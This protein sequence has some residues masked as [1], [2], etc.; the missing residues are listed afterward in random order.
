VCDQVAKRWLKVAEIA[1]RQHGVISTGQLRN[2]GLDKHAVLH[3]RRSGF[4]HAVH[5]GVYA[6][7][8]PGISIEGRWMAAVL[9]CG[10]SRGEAAA[11]TALGRWRAALSHRSAAALWGLLDSDSGGVDVTVQGDAG[12][13][14][15]RGIRVHRSVSLTAAD[16]T[17]LRRIPV[18]KPA[19]TIADLRRMVSSRPGQANI[20]A[21]EVR[22]AIRQ[23]EVLGLAAAPGL[24]AQTRSELERR[25]LGLCRR[26]DLPMPEVNVRLGA[27]E[28][29][30]LWQAASLVVETDG[31]RFHRGR[32]AF[33]DDRARDLELQA[34]GYA[35]IRLTHRQLI[36]DPARIAEILR[37][38]I[39]GAA[40][41]AD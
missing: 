40:S 12:R 38:A 24:D 18:T 14:S 1:S 9:A 32:I 17:I 6:V 41:A 13:T 20:T 35:V 22:R 34:Q 15:R 31:Y 25:L 23:A 16:V 33:E 11:S 39:A 27:I 21:R 36:G 5:R 8:H 26:H 19:R 30:F 29:D 37:K 7:G 28:V 4:L 2:A 10:G 3:R